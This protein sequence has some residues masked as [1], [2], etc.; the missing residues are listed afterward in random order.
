M[1]TGSQFQLAQTPISQNWIQTRIDLV[2]CA[3]DKRHIIQLRKEQREAVQEKIR[4]E[5]LKKL[6]VFERK[7]ENIFT[8]KKNS[9]RVIQ[10]KNYMSQLK[11]DLR[12]A[13]DRLSSQQ[14]VRHKTTRN[15]SMTRDTSRDEFVSDP[16]MQYHQNGD[17]E[18]TIQSKSRQVAGP[19]D[20]SQLLDSAESSIVAIR[21]GSRAINASA[22]APEREAYGKCSSQPQTAKKRRGDEMESNSTTHPTQSV[23]HQEKQPYEV[24]Y[25]SSQANHMKHKSMV[26]QKHQERF[27]MRGALEV[28]KKHLKQHS[29]DLS[30][31]FSLADYCDANFNKKAYK[32]FTKQT[33]RAE[34]NKTQQIGDL[35]S[36]ITHVDRK[37]K[38]K[39]NRPMTSHLQRSRDMP[40]HQRPNSQL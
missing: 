3:E 28:H 13:R 1:L 6:D 22:N 20:L 4:E 30:S 19:S 26:M 7:A 5:E 40:R 8:S 14:S 27:G 37:R 12:Q 17:Y 35:D 36:Q 25:A 32:D 11:K 2:A 33:R 10:M 15:E 31:N 21:A 16:A 38:L 23:S 9:R 24:S 29:N 34:F 39:L 18:D